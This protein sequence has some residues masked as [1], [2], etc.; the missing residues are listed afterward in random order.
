MNS[1]EINAVKFTFIV[2]FVGFLMVAGKAFKIQVIDK[3]K[4]VTKSKGQYFRSSKVYPRRGNI[5]DRNGNP[6]AINI[7]T[8]SIFTIPKNVKDKDKT[9]KSLSKILPNHSLSYIKNRIKK[10]KRFTWIARKIKLSKDQVKA[11]KELKG[12]YIDS[13]PKRLYPN[14][15]LL[16]QLIGF[17]GIDNA[18]L[19][20]IEY[21]FDKDLRGKPQVTKYIKDNKGRPVKFEKVD[22]GNHAKDINL[23]IDKEIQ[24]IAEKYL[25]EA[26][27]KYNANKGGIGVMDVQTGEILAMANYPTFDPNKVKKSDKKYRKLSFVSDPFEPG[28]TF[29]LFTAASALENKIATPNTNYYCEGGKLRVSGHIINEAESAKKYEWLSLEE[30]IRYSSN[31]G[32]TKMAFDLTF[33]RLYKTLESLGI[34]VKTDIEL[35]GESRG[36]LINDENVSPIKL[37]NISFG[38]GVATTGIQMLAAYGAIANNGIYT[39]PTILKNQPLK[40]RQK[41]V[42]SEKTAHQLTDML[43][44]A[45]E[46]GTGGNAKIKYFS[47]A[48]KT[49]TAQRPDKDGGYKGYVPGFIGY[50][51]NVKD[52]FV[53]YVY[54]DNPEGKKYYGNLVATPVFKKVAEH[55]LF[56]NKE[57]NDIARKSDKIQKEQFESFKPV[58][59]RRR[60]IV[61]GKM[62]DF[63]GLDKKTAME[64]AR[65]WGLKILHRGIGV[66]SK[67]S[68]VPGNPLDRDTPIR[69]FYT[70]P[71]YE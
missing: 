18:G 35:P 71:S 24:Y 5:Y 55:I 39:R 52:R 65:K 51:T 8:Y 54:V 31:I 19:S 53:I 16:S 41:R 27:L 26:V 62:P 59:K 1:K 29:K 34:G 14:G 33:P 45:V 47:I 4:L 60:S 68:I 70:P 3:D 9:Y 12:V 42:M 2:F 30:I 40:E 11:I 13:V 50:P 64:I 46:D 49:S 37:S 56:K 20:G 36:I 58:T 6:M 25:K 17:V 32:T 67:Q 57:F 38:Q 22:K 28:S 43:V 63:I 44:K 21:L 23:T 66:V 48:G 15:E 61:K 69:L 10:R 7:Q